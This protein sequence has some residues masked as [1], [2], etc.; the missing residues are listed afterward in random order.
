MIKTKTIFTK[1][2]NLIGL[3]QRI[4]NQNPQSALMEINETWNKFFQLNIAGSILEPKN[5]GEIIAVY[6]QFESDYL[7]PYTLTIGCAVNDLNLNTIKDLPSG[8]VTLTIPAS[9]YQVYTAKGPMPEALGQ[10]WAAIW[11]AP[12]ER[13]Y[14]FDFELYDQRYHYSKDKEVDIYIGIK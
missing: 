6:H 3:S 1:E 2:I 8:C 11:E 14:H 9:K 12:L 10:T 13:S 4:A 5:P 7:G